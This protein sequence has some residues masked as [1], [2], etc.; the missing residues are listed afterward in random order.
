MK[1][2]LILITIFLLFIIFNVTLRYNLSQDKS[3]YKHMIFQ[4]IPKNLENYLIKIED[5]RFYKHFGVDFISIIRATYKNIIWKKQ[6][7]ST[8]DQ[9]VIKLSNSQ[10]TN[11]NIFTKLKEILLAININFHYSKENILK[12]YVNNVN[13]PYWVKWF[14]SA[15]K[16]F[17]NNECNKLYSSQLLFLIAMYQT[18]KNPFENFK[19]IKNRSKILAKYLWLDTKNY[20]Y[21]PPRSIKDIFLNI[22]E[23]KLEKNYIKYAK[24]NINKKREKLVNNI[25]SSSKNYRLSKW[26]KDCCILIM[27]KNQNIKAIWVCRNIVDWNY[28]NSC[29]KKRQVW[30]ALKPFIYLKSMIDFWY[31]WWTIVEDKPVTFKLD[32]YWL[33]S[34]KNFDMKYHWKIPIS[35]ALWNSLNIPA[36]LMINKIWV[37]NFIKFINNLRLFLSDIK[38]NI[39][40]DKKKFTEE[41]LWLSVALW[42]YELNTREFANL[43][44][45]FLDTNL[46]LQFWWKKF[47]K[48]TNEI[49]NILSQNKNRLIS[50][51]LENN[52]NKVWRAVKTWTSRNFTDWRTCWANK[53]KWIIVCVWA[54]NHNWLSMK[55]SWVNTAWWL[56][57]LV[58]DWIK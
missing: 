41:N 3:S 47:V 39:V 25:I 22:P 20:K 33:Y 9:Q 6:W 55:T 53:Q 12:Y 42:T 7:A 1:K 54:W 14:K 2:L 24:Y 21:L 38:T 45:I 56:R 5:K 11:R 44:R 27:D 36:V 26:F 19:Y 15:C 43:W 4:S 30:S 23:P 31:T 37:L 35:I 52:L 8:I 57:S 28:I 50:F 34:P 16:I 48:A 18:W 32:K 51:W 58:V 49:V 13:F 17:F 46:Q 40:R 10:F 29:F